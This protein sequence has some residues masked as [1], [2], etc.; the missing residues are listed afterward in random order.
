MIPSVWSVCV[1]GKNGLNLLAIC[2]ACKAGVL[3]ECVCS[4]LTLLYQGG[5]IDMG[6]APSRESCVGNIYSDHL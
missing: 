4:K 1:V 5:C 2:N 3:F 6:V